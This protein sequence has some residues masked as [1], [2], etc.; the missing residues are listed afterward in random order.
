MARL[1]FQRP[2]SRSE[3]CGFRSRQSPESRF[4]RRRSSGRVVDAGAACMVRSMRE[5]S[6]RTCRARNF[7]G[8]ILLR[9]VQGASLI[10]ELQ[11]S[12]APR[13][14]TS[15]RDTCMGATW[16]AAS[17]QQCR[18]FRAHRFLARS[19]RARRC[20]KHS[21]RQLIFQIL[22][23]GEPTPRRRQFLR[24]RQR[25]FRTVLNRGAP[26]SGQITQTNDFRGTTT[27]IIS[28]VKCWMRSRGARHASKRSNASIV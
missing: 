23:S 28:Y 15:G 21:C 27:P 16:K 6:G 17:L 26:Y 4:R 5:T 14:T 12:F 7:R 13:C 10:C 8:P 9:T 3:G 2:R 22:C 11:G 25:D 18:R 24:L 1:H 19:F 20:N